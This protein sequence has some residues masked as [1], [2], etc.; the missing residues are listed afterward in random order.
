MSF[1]MKKK[2]H[3]IYFVIYIYIG[4]CGNQRLADIGGPPFLIPI[5]Q[6]DKV[7]VTLCTRFINPLPNCKNNTKFYATCKVVSA[8]L[9]HRTT[10]CSRG[11]IRITPCPFGIVRCASCGVHHAVCIV[12]RRLFF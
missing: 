2:N 3:F 12:R 8:I 11:A 10:T 9:V 1:H 6:K 4:L 5:P 7:I